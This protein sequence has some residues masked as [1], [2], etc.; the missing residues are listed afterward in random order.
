M[1]NEKMRQARAQVNEVR[2]SREN[3]KML[4]QRMLTLK[5]NIENMQ[6]NRQDPQQIEAEAKRQK[7][8]EKLFYFA[9]YFKKLSI[10]TV[11][12]L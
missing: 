8:V 9:V 7:Q 6:A 2:S 12:S 5:R 10:T 11:E 1:L 3:L 4:D